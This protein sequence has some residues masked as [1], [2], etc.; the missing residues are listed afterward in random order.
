MAEQAQAVD[1]GNISELNGSAQILR[2]K[3]YKATESFDI[4]QNDEAVT[5]NGRMAITFLD[6]SKVRLIPSRSKAVSVPAIE[7]RPP[8]MFE[9][10]NCSKSRF[11]VA[12][13]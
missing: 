10:P 5:T 3:P 2:D 1:I 7:F 6:D 11:A 8:I 12:P 9:D 13:D 4:Q